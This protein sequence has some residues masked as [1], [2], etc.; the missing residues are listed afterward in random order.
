MGELGVGVVAAEGAVAADTSSP[1]IFSSSLALGLGDRR[2]SCFP[3]SDS[4]NRIGADGET[5]K[6]WK[7]LGLY[8]ALTPAGPPIIFPSPRS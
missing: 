4:K 8:G 3:V 7:G 6:F 2:K 1:N 5:T